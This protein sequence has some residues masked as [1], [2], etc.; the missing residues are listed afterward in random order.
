MIKKMT[1]IKDDT[2]MHLLSNGSL[3][4][5]NLDDILTFDCFPFWKPLAKGAQNAD[6]NRMWL[7]VIC[8]LYIYINRCETKCDVNS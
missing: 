7:H 3:F 1:T 8:N 2:C 6:H 5:R 4:K